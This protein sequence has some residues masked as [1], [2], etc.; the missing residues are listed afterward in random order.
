[1]SDT[2]VNH[3]EFESA[4]QAL[5]WLFDNK[6]SWLNPGCLHLWQESFATLGGGNLAGGFSWI[7]KESLKGRV[8]SVRWSNDSVGIVFHDQVFIDR[9]SNRSYPQET[10]C[11]KARLPFIIESDIP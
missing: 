5:E 10:R 11:V 2:N 9:I 8:Y 3:W 7:S 6:T 4:E 1:M